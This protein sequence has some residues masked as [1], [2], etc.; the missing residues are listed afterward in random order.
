MFLIYFVLLKVFSKVF[1]FISSSVKRK[2]IDVNTSK[3]YL[4]SAIFLSL[5]GMRRRKCPLKKYDL[6]RVIIRKVLIGG[7]E[8]F[9]KK[10]CLTRK[11]WSKNR[12]AGDPRNYGQEN[13][14][15]KSFVTLSGFAFLIFF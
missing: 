10:R 1:Y 2:S 7:L 12:G 11:M 13:P 15:C 3:H 14:C 6:E 9:Q 8:V 5:S 4:K